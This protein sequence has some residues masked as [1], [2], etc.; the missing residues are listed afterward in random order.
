M[1]NQLTKDKVLEI[2]TM[3]ALPYEKPVPKETNEIEVIDEENVVIQELSVE[4]KEAPK[5]AKKESTTDTNNDDSVDGD[6]EGQIT[7]F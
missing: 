3:E 7:L 1:G 2:N 4:P 6:E 5:P